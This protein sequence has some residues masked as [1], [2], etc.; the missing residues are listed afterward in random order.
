MADTRPAPKPKKDT[1]TKTVDDSYE[2]PAKKK[3]TKKK[4]YD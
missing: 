2:K 3:R 4:S 1:T